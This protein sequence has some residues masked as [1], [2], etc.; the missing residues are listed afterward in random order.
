MFDSEIDPVM[1]SNTEKMNFLITQIA[2]MN[3]Q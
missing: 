1:M 2:A 3:E